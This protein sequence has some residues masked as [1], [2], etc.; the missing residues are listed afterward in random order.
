MYTMM[1]CTYGP[2]AT[3]GERCGAPAVV[4]FGEFAECET[5]ALTTTTPVIAE[6]P[7]PRFCRK[8]ACVEEAMGYEFVGHLAG[9]CAR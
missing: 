9:T 4:E 8:A 3:T 6:A 7:K 5:H 1:T 2:T